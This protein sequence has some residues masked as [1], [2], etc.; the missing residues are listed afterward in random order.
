MK[1][2]SLRKSKSAARRGAD[3]QVAEFERRDLGSDIRSARTARLLRGRSKPTS[4]VLDEDLV[5][6][7]RAKAAKRGLGYQTM[8]KMIVREHLDEY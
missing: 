4:I 5:R 1:K 2:Q 8:L 6:R 7:L 3:A